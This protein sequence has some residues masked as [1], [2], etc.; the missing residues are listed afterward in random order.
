MPFLPDPY[1]DTEQRIGRGVVKN[2]D[3]RITAI[4]D[5]IAANNNNPKPFV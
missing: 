2:V 1:F 3:Q 4:D 5:Y